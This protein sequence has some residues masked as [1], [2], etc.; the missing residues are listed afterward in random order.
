MRSQGISKNESKEKMG[1]LFAKREDR[2]RT[3]GKKTVIFKDGRVIGDDKLDRWGA[4]HAATFD[5]PTHLAAG[6]LNRKRYLTLLLTCL[7]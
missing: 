5:A 1:V 2:W 7:C 3:Q 6:E 4:K